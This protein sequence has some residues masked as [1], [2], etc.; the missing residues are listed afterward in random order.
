[1]SGSPHLSGLLMFGKVRKLY[2]L[3]LV[4]N[5]RV[6]RVLFCF[7]VVIR[8]GL[9]NSL[10]TMFPWHATIYIRRLAA[11]R[12]QAEEMQLDLD[13][14]RIYESE[15]DGHCH[16]MQQRGLEADQELNTLGESINF[17][18]CTQG[19]LMLNCP[20]TVCVMVKTFLG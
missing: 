20:V 5:A 1:M 19:V 17:E 8:L 18:V 14:L 15:L 6:F 2:M 13:K 9:G 12:K 7:C 11:A 3:Q 4:L 16:K 10:E